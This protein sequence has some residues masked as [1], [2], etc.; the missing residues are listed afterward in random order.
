MNVIK[1]RKLT[2]QQISEF[3]GSPR[4]IRAFEDAQEDIGA[5][6]EAL[7]TAQFLTLS[8]NPNLGNERVLTLD[9]ADLVGV[10]SD[11]SFTVSLAE[12]GAAGVYGSATQTLAVTVDA[13]GRVAEIVVAELNTDNITE[14]GT[15]LYFTESRARASISAGDNLAYDSVTGEMSMPGPIDVTGEIRGDSLQL[16]ATPSSSSATTTHKLA[17]ILNGSTYYLL[18][19]NV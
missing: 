6:Y 1:T 9:P 12:L 10:T 7:S 13:K 15:N 2:R 5:Q 3:V 18:L 19:S 8:D 14:G 17:V 11:A 4:G 16:N